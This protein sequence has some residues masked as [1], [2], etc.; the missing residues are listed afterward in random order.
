MNKTIIIY[1]N[2]FQNNRLYKI[3]F[4]VKKVHRVKKFQLKNKKNK[5]G[6]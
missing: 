1:N 4:K 3:S 6:L 5:Q 2:K